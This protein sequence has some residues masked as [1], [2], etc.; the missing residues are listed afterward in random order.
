MICVSYGATS[1]TG[2]SL[3]RPPALRMAL[4]VHGQKY[5]PVNSSS[6]IRSPTSPPWTR[7]H[8]TA[9]WLTLTLPVPFRATGRSSPAP[10]APGQE[11]IAPVALLGTV[12]RRADGLL[13]IWCDAT[14]D[15]RWL[16][17]DAVVRNSGTSLIGRRLPPPKGGRARFHATGSFLHWNS[18]WQVLL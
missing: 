6:A 4:K 15:A 1:T 11:V 3:I 8:R 12:T 2:C 7:A 18:S 5:D 16:G 10:T 9:S 13:V 17:S 14:P